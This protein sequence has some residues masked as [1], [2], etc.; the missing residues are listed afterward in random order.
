MTVLVNGD[1][2]DEANETFFVNLSN[3]SNVTIADGQGVGTITDNDPLP[4]VSVNDVTVTE[5]NGGTVAATFTLTPQ[6]PERPQPSRSTTRPPTGPRPRRPTTR[7][8]AARSPSRPA[9]P[10]SR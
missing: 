1:L 3:P 10:P 7:R 9:R 6:R 5:G 8:R 2:L 4:T